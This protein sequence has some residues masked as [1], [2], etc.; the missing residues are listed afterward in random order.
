MTDDRRLG[1]SRRRR[2]ASSG[3][4]DEAATGLAMATVGACQRASTW[5]SST[6]R[7]R[8]QFG[9]PIG[10]FQAVK[11]KFVDMYVAVERAR[12]LGLLRGARRS[13]RTTPAGRCRLDGQGRR[14]R[15]PAHRR[16]ARH[17]AL[18]RH[19]LHVGER[20]AAVRSGGPR[21]A[22]C[23]SERAAEHRARV[24]RIVVDEARVRAVKLTL[25]RR[26]R[27]VPRASSRRG[28]T[29]T[30]RP[31]RGDRAAAARRRRDIPAW[32]RR[33][34]AR[35]VR[36]RLA[37]AGLAARARRPQ[38]RPARADRLPR[39]A[40]PPRDHASFN[41]QGLGIIAPSIL[42]YGTDEQKQRWALPILRA[43]I[44]AALGMSE[45][46]AG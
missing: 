13:P 2:R 10:S 8:E 1:R 11:H 37:R 32:A 12:A 43:E 18:R 36:R 34:A 21:P 6:S 20:P 15:L 44:T 5:R 26:H 45:P 22:S 7:E 3:A 24:G 4:V 33:V 28:S 19:R 42:D 29:S 16:P 17:P 46:D 27:G 41:P 25:R 31:A 40:G 9:V 23:C 14:R 38:R 39:G 30:R 35:A